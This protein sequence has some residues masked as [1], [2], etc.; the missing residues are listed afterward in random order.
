MMDKIK[1]ILRK[2]KNA[3]VVLVEENEP[4]YVVLNFDEYERLSNKQEEIPFSSPKRFLA[5]PSGE[6]QIFNEVNQEII[7]LQAPKEDVIE[8]IV[9]EEIMPAVEP[10]EIK[11]EDIPLL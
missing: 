2:N 8:D 4:A 9:L 11:I 6:D 3:F 10:Q 1:K 7:N 5:E